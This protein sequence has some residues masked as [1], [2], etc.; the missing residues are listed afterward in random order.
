MEHDHNAAAALV[1][2]LHAARSYNV[3]PVTADKATSERIVRALERNESTLPSST[4]LWSANTQSDVDTT[5]SLAWTL[6]ELLRRDEQVR[7]N[8]A[9]LRTD[10]VLH[11]IGV[12]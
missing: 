6:K 9:A 11:G 4:V 3:L 10:G 7:Q 5:A 2:Q 12:G 1:A 8:L